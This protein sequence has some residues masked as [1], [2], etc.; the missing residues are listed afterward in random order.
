MN[1]PTMVD[2]NDEAHDAG[3]VAWA[4]VDA[5]PD[6]LVVVDEAG[7]IEFANRQTEEVFGFDRSE[8]IG[9]SVEMLL[10]ERLWSV[11]AAH[12]TRYRA[13]PEVRPMGRGLDL[14]A[15]RR[16]GSEFPVDV[17]L[18]PFTSHGD[19]RIIAAVRDISD[20]IAARAREDEVR[21]VLDA[22]EDGVYIFDADSLLFT[23]V[24]QGAVK[25]VGYSE[26]QLMTMGPLHIKQAFVESSFRE[27]LAPLLAGDVR[28]T[29]FETLHRRRDGI[30]V[31]VEIV[32]QCPTRTASHGRVCVALVRDIRD[33]VQHESDLE[34]A[35]R[36]ASLLAERERIARDMHDTVMSRLFGV[37]M[38]LQ[39]TASL[40]DD[41]E[42]ATR[43]EQM[44]AEI[45]EALLEIR[46]TV[47]GLR[48]RQ[49]WGTGVRGHVLAV[50]AEQRPILGFEPRVDFT[51]PIDRLPST[52]VD[53]L[54][55]TLRESLTN[56]AR[57]ARASQVTIDVTA[58][59]GHVRL[60]VA[61]D[62]VG[63]GDPVGHGSGDATATT[64]HGLRNMAARAQALGGRLVISS[65]PGK[66]AT[67]DWSVPI[68]PH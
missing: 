55:A 29:H 64:G 54:L 47:Y 18:S 9:Q 41:P 56:V 26:D 27:L 46:S 67:I 68:D 25:Q 13:E 36:R 3:A 43:L 34:D 24:N 7:Q 33:R 35:R 28:S 1:P 51:G 10:P 58:E 14:V 21:H 20:R 39:G 42:I 63:F 31:P 40:V 66:G 5:I 23:Y 52:V 65:T 57:Y 22:V 44:T 62:G 30:D 37:G 11:H 59:Q 6:A 8:L 38:A 19:L 12:R 50:A 15:R 2:R 16:D 32:L 4:M 53:E 60:V 45:D 48:S 49:D 17:S 61:D